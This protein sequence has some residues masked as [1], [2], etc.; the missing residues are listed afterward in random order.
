[1]KKEKLIPREVPATKYQ[2]D[3][4][5]LIGKEIALYKDGKLVVKD[6]LIMV[7]APEHSPGVV[8]LYFDEM[9]TATID[10]SGVFT[11]KYMDKNRTAS[12]RP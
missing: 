10:G 6:K 11:I 9:S 3:R 12:Y 4:E 2:I 7:S 5:G 8:G 1:M